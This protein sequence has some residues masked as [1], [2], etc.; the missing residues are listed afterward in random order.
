[1]D[2]RENTPDFK[3]ESPNYTKEI[4]Q[5]VQAIAIAIVIALL[6]RGFVFEL[7]LVQGESM[8]NTL[9]TGQRLFV[10]KLGYYLHPPKR[11]DIIVLQYQEGTINYIPFID[12]APFLKKIFPASNEV[13]YIKRVIGVPGDII[14]ISN[15]SVYLN[16]D[17][18]TEPYAKGITM[19]QVMEFP[20][21]VPKD[22]VLVMGDNRQN[23][24]DSRQI[25]FID[26]SK[27]KGK[28]EFRIYPLNTMGSIYT[29]MK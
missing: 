3:N 24:S 12:K 1:M 22:K 4:M 5:W 18:L 7:V 28:A 19:R 16:G 2:F 14:D 6:I 17:K 10:Y 15:G 8:Q 11:G 27:I 9:Q 29:N 13:D 23:S 25:G 21:R 26:Y 20:V